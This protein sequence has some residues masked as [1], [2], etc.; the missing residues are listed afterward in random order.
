MIASA[1]YAQQLLPRGKAAVCCILPRGIVWT[2]VSRFS[3]RQ[4]KIDG[5]QLFIFLI[6]YY[7]IR[8]RKG[9]VGGSAIVN[10]YQVRAQGRE[11]K[12]SLYIVEDLGVGGGSERRKVGG[13]CVPVWGIRR[14]SRSTDQPSFV[15]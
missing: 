15:L 1:A 11:V 12:D 4:K 3:P 7:Y 9:K 14:Q 2:H 5:R 6:Y 10:S 8:V 13:E